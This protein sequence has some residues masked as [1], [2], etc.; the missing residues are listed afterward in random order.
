MLWTSEAFPARLDGNG[1]GQALYDLGAFEFDPWQTEAL[2][3]AQKSSDAY[4]IITDDGGYSGS[5]GNWLHSNAAG[6]FVT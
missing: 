5:M 3:V 1:D 6:D 2:R 4:S